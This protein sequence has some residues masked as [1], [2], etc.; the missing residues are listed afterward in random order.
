MAGVIEKYRDEGYEPSM[1]LS[2][3]QHV[4]RGDATNSRAGE[5]KIFVSDVLSLFH[6]NGIPGELGRPYRTMQLSYPDVAFVPETFSSLDAFAMWDKLLTRSGVHCWQ[7][8]VDDTY[9]DPCSQ[10]LEKVVNDDGEEEDGEGAGVFEQVPDHD[11]VDGIAD[12]AWSK[13]V[14]MHISIF[15]FHTDAGPDQFGCASKLAGY[16]AFVPR[17]WTIWSFCFMHQIH[18]MAGRQLKRLSGH[19]SNLAKL[20]HL[21]R[22]PGAAVKLLRV[23]AAPDLLG[24]DA[25][26]V[27]SSLPPR[28]LTRRWGSIHAAE[29]FYLRFSRKVLCATF[30]AVFR[31]DADEGRQ[32]RGSLAEDPDG[33]R[34]GEKMGR[35][36]RDVLSALHSDSFWISL[37]LGHITRSPIGRA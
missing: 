16:F 24:D 1:V 36:L 19:Y 33:E 2:W 31:K 35:W 4:V 29:S 17:V 9:E 34:Y 22:S 13:G 8:R 3:E 6:H 14:A 21:W 18:L 20:T 27:A 10:Y 5:Q 23:L 25:K 11:K 37:H 7:S 28:P 12:V 30:N 26:R 32:D 15:N